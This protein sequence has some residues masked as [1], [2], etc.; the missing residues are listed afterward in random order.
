MMSYTQVKAVC[1]ILMLA[2]HDAARIKQNAA[3]AAAVRE[4]G[5][6]RTAAEDKWADLNDKCSWSWMSMACEGESHGMAC[7]HRPLPMDAMYSDSCRLS[8]QSMLER[9]NRKEMYLLQAELLS[10][11]SSKFTKDCYATSW[12]NIKGTMR[13]KR[14]AQHM[15]RA[16]EFISKSQTSG[17]MKSL[18]AEEQ[19]VGKSAMDVS[20]SNIT[21]ALG[22]DGEAILELR[23]KMKANP[24]L[25]RKNPKEAL[26]QVVEQTWKLLRGDDKQRK[27][28]RQDIKDMTEEYPENTEVTCIGVA[29]GHGRSHDAWCNSNCNHKP[30][31]C[32]ASHCKCAAPVKTKVPP[33]TDEDEAEAEAMAKELEEDVEGAREVLDKAVTGFEQVGKKDAVT[34]GGSLMQQMQSVT[35]QVQSKDDQATVILKGFLFVLIVLLLWQA[36]AGVVMAMLGIFLTLIFLSLLACG[37]GTV[38]NMNSCGTSDLGDLVSC[39]IQCAKRMIKIP[40]GWVKEIGQAFGEVFN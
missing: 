32:P 38:V 28:A 14:R 17:F 33:P 13:C 20:L 23:N 36:I 18:T 31:H 25:V 24:T 37:L 26:F 1:L 9:H 34:I 30:A 12:L 10:A 4:V 21:A 11:K 19:S 6:P 22:V 2:G 15:M 40:I 7:T 29:P 3:T 5:G 27:K 8:D 16:M 39:E 35:Q